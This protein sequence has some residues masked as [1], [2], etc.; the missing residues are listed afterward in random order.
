MYKLKA[1]AALVL[2][3]FLAASAQAQTFYQGIDYANITYSES[4]YD[5]EA[6]LKAL[7]YKIG[8]RPI[9]YLAF[10]GHLMKGIGSDTVNVGGIDI[11]MELDNG[12]GLYT[13]VIFPVQGSAPGSEEK[14]KFYV[15]LG[16]TRGS[17]T[18]S[19]M[20]LSLS[21]TD[22]DFSYGFGAEILFTKHFAGTLE[23]MQFIDKPGFE[24]SG[25]CTGIKIYF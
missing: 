16:Y 18:A 20:G 19:S 4:G 12:F 11:K 5:V 25:L 22:S 14:G 3:L 13:L 9:S 23:Y 17:A 15:I 24:Y 1:I 7:R 2:L 10:E 6:K 21:D 8:I